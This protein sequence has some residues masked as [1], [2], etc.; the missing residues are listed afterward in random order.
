M[1]DIVN[2]LFGPLDASYCN[3]FYVL[4]IIGFVF[5]VFSVAGFLFGLTKGK[6][7]NI[8]IFVLLVQ[9]FLTYFLNRLLYSICVGSLK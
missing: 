2:Y 1:Q 9:A 7:G 4:S 8:N 5:F 6:K 3:Y